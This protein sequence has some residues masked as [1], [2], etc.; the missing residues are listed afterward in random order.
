MWGCPLLALGK[1]ANTNK[2][3]VKKHNINQIFGYLLREA[4][5]EKLIGQ[6]ENIQKRESH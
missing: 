3:K 4:G 5:L 6:V 1:N 2:R